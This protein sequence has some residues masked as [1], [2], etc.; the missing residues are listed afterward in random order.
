MARIVGMLGVVLASIA[1]I[2]CGGRDLPADPYP[3]TPI[4]GDLEHLRDEYGRYVFL[5]GINT[6]G[7]DKIPASIDANGVPSYVGK[8][9]PLD[10]ADLHFAT[11]QSMGFNVIRLLILWEGLQPTGPDTIDTAYVAY[12][13]EIAKA[14]G[15]H[16]IRVLLEMHQDDFT[17]HIFA[18]YNQHPT[19]GA[20]G[21]LENTLAALLPPYDDVV[22]GNGAPRWVVSAVLPERDLSSPG[23]GIPRLVSGLK[24]GDITGF[25]NAVRTL[26]GST[27]T[28]SAEFVQYF[29][30][31]LP[32][33]FPL[34]ATTDFLPLSSWGLSAAIS[35]DTARCWGSFF[36]GRTLFP[37][38]THD[39]KNIQ[40]Y[41]QDAFVDSWRALAVAVADLP[42]VAG[43]DVYNEP[44]ANFLVL[45]AVA[46]A[47]K[48]G[49][50]DGALG[51]L[52]GVLGKEQGQTIYDLLVAFGI[53]PPD[54]TPETLHAWG[55]DQLDFGAALSVNVNY[56]ETFMRPF[57]EKLGAA[58]QQADPDAVI[59]IEP[60]L[61]ASTIF[62]G[63][64][65]LTQGMWDQSMRAPTLPHPD[66]L[67]FAA[68][69]YPDMYPFP[70]FLR[71]PRNFNPEEVRYRDYQ[72]SIEQVLAPATHSLG[73]LPAVF[74]EF[75]MFFDFN[76]IETARAQDYIVTTVLL[77]NYFEA[78]ER[79]NV[80]RLLWD[81]NPENSW[82]FGDLWNHEDLS[83]IDPDG[84][85]RAVDGWDRPHPNA[86]AGKPVSMHYWS[87]VHTFDPDKGEV[88][89]YGEFQMT[90]RG[91]A[92]LAPTEVFVPQIQYPDGFFVRIS[93]GRCDWDPAT[94]ILYHHP[95]VD[96]PDALHTITLRRPQEGDAQVGWNYFIQGNQVVSR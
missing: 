15:R 22:S 83:I 48:L 51:M 61:S 87:D 79:L 12:L 71:T 81:Y 96:D 95:E 8:P 46:A 76:G 85:W 54:T 78:L 66:Q 74:G 42:N 70:S 19:I 58:I 28:P 35:I 65:S 23:W 69:W 44:N 31:H 47:V 7:G 49:A 52:Q 29:Q 59:W 45:A 89:A 36:A 77:N 94:Q 90:Y 40:D 1:C 20:P 75:G 55:L 60:A 43:Y 25:V 26:T 11:M 34:N 68:H 86:L 3:L 39:G 67:V 62:A 4:H 30:D 72:A 92:T 63:S 53:L 41:L 38:L 73:N 80:S 50:I 2:A 27:D 24:T 18:R 84:N 21:S 82:E 14:A 37:N 5:N 32:G 10:Q 88:P 56:E 33:P 13:R 64:G 57:W 6:S 17:R 16:G 93:D 9:F 91:R